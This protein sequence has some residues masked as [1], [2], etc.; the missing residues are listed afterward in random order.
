[1]GSDSLPPQDIWDPGNGK[2]A[3]CTL[4]SLSDELGFL[5]EKDWGAQ[6]YIEGLMSVEGL[7]VQHLK[8]LKKSPGAGA[9]G[10]RILGKT[11]TKNILACVLIG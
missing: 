7:G 1:M 4:L 6:N 5:G 11:H 9:G 8:Y 3:L 2:C 10:R